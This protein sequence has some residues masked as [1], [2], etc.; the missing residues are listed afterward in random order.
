M[1]KTGKKIRQNLALKPLGF[2]SHKYEISARAALLAIK[3]HVHTEQHLIDLFVL[4]DISELLSAERYIRVHAA[5]VKNL[6]EQAH[7]T[8]RVGHLEYAAM[9]PSAD[10]LLGFF[11]GQKNGDIARVCLEAADAI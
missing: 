2:K 9:E 4:A 3:H 11:A 10:V 5:S 6:I 1:R 7:Q 8:G